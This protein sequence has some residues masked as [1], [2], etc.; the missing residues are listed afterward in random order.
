MAFGKK[1]I[2]SVMQVNPAI[3]QLCQKIW[4]HLNATRKGMNG[5]YEAQDSWY[6]QIKELP[7]GEN[8]TYDRRELLAWIQGPFMSMSGALDTSTFTIAE[9]AELFR[10]LR[11]EGVI[12]FPIKSP[13]CDIDE[14]GK[15]TA[16]GTSGD[17]GSGGGGW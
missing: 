12:D 1:K 14:N 6:Y 9:I 5:A 7:D 2:D 3:N 13:F 10:W 17:C 4:W 8:V 16:G 11:D 15:A